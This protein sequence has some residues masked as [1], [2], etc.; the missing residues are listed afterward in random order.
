M[1]AAT[2]IRVRVADIHEGDI[3]DQPGGWTALENA[4]TMND[5]TVFVLV[6]FLDGGNG[7]RVWDDASTEVPVIR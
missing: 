7:M 1:T 2:H 3:L 6:G 4:T 5:G